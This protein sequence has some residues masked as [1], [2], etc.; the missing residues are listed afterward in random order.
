MLNN[1][2]KLVVVNGIMLT[3]S[4]FLWRHGYVTEAM[5][6]DILYII[7]TIAI[8][9]FIGFI[10]MLYSAS[11]YKWASG[12]TLTLGLM[13]TIL[14]LHTI[15]SGVDPASIGDVSQVSKV[16]GTLL[17]GTGQAFWTTLVGAYFFLWLTLIGEVL[18]YEG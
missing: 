4:F 2:V 11:F 15:F 18:G 9:A 1:T 12:A 14:G 6:N 10:S 7:P 16:I 3:I 17:Q 13:G 8:V 5:N